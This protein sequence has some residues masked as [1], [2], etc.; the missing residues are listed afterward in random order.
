MQKLEERRRK[1]S[2]DADECQGSSLGLEPAAT[3]LSGHTI[4]L[5]TSPRD[6]PSSFEHLEEA[7]AVNAQ[8]AAQ[9]CATCIQ[10]QVKP[11]NL[12]VSKFIQK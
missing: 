4:N 8:P 7:E 3:Q 10:C 9:A 5:A 11:C 1:L 6:E 2:D 12:Y